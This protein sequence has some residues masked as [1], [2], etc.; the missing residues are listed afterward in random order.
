M[1][2]GISTWVGAA[3]GHGGQ[4]PI[5]IS[6]PGSRDLVR[7]RGMQGW[8][9]TKS[10]LP[11][12]SSCHPPPRAP[13]RRRQVTA[14]PPPRSPPLRPLLPRCPPGSRRP[15]GE[16]PG[17]GRGAG[18]RVGCG[19]R[20]P[21]VAAWRLAPLWQPFSAAAAAG[22]LRSEAQ[23]A[24]ARQR[25]RGRRGAGSPAGVSAG[26]R[27][28]GG[29]ARGVAGAP[30]PSPCC[31]AGRAGPLRVAS[32]RDPTLSPPSCTR[33]GAFPKPSRRRQSPARA[34]G[35]PCSPPGLG[36]LG[37]PGRRGPGP[38]PS[39]LGGRVCPPNPKEAP[40]ATATRA[41]PAGRPGPPST[42]GRRAGP[43][44]SLQPT[45]VAGRGVPRGRGG[46]EGWALF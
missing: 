41:A 15:G 20:P 35:G 42:A 4:Q 40:R 38:R 30:R 46:A 31:N 44:P 14:P 45:L 28:G 5:S 25:R 17:E 23:A 29:G 8:G 12:L 27:S 19:A 7:A 9:Q 2:T 37:A 32:A 13:P 3:R 18:L 34:H 36:G 21:P 10:A 1:R 6:P 43:E 26:G 39:P 11:A 16:S 24:A 33:A 22:A